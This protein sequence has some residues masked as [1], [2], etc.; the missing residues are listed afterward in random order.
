M[1]FAIQNHLMKKSAEQMLKNSANV[2]QTPSYS[3]FPYMLKQ[4]VNVTPPTRFSHLPPFLALLD[5]T[6][7]YF[8]YLHYS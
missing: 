6:H 2:Q 4:S 3:Y 8:A 1:P 7:P 5:D